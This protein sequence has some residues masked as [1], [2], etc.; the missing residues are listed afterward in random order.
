MRYSLSFTLRR[1][2]GALLRSLA[3]AERRGYLISDLD[4]RPSLSGGHLHVR[5]NVAAVG[6]TPSQ[7]V[8]QLQ[9]LIDVVEAEVFDQHSESSS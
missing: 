6:R 7:L 2:S 5:M 3:L 9:K 4:V 8:Q 1:R